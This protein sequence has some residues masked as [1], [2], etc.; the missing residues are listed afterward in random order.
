MALEEAVVYW[1]GE[2]SPLH[3]RI[4]G[5]QARKQQ[6]EMAQEIVRC[7]QSEQHSVIEAPTGVG[8][9]LGY[10]IPILLAGKKTLIA[11][12]TKVLQEQLLKKDLPVL[13]AAM[14][15]SVR[16]EML[17]GKENYLSK[18]RLYM[19]RE[20]ATRLSQRDFRDLQKIEKWAQITSTGDKADCVQVRPDASIW[21]IVCTRSQDVIEEEDFCAIAR[22]RA[23]AADILIVNQH[24]LCA[25]IQ[26][27]IQKVSNLLSDFQVFIIDE[28]HAFPET[29]GLM[30]SRQANFATLRDLCE[31]VERAISEKIADAALLSKAIKSLYDCAHKGR[32][33]F[34]PHSGRKS[35]HELC[36]ESAVITDWVVE[37]IHCI[38]QLNTQLEINA[39]RDESIADLYNRGQELLA[40]WRDLYERSEQGNKATDIVWTEVSQEGYF[41]LYITPMKVAPVVREA[42]DNTNGNWIFTSATLAIQ[43]DFSLFT[44][45]IGVE[46][47]TLCLDSPFNYG[48]QGLLYLPKLPEPNWQNDHQLEALLETALPVLQLTEGRAFLLFTSFKALDRAKE[49]LEQ[50]SDFKLFVQGERSSQ[51]L[52]D[53]FRYAKKSLLLGTATFWEGVDIKGAALSCVIIDK[54]PFASPNDPLV[55]A[56]RQWYD[57]AGRDFFTED[58]LARAI[59][60]LRQG[61]GRLIRSQ[62]DKGILLIGDVRLQSKYYGKT[63]LENLPAFKRCHDFDSVKKFWES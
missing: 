63:I 41:R 48:E 3:E 28:A 44:Q 30:F 51:D 38:E 35:W 25:D 47:R 17:K 46:A 9:T 4:E 7:V 5:F 31:D 39:E 54:L 55:K 34:A 15:C 21:S 33:Y 26:L 24:L 52:L 27:Q 56:R 45:R 61:I 36:A 43:Q 16:V 20:E 1:C 11:S 32:K 12:R 18:N 14:S 57:D 42:I 23:R 59:L 22:R 58:A 10:L 6:Q 19:A 62:Q 8:K 29:A 49:W 40:L 13:L 50:R 37:L 60:Q 2:K 53:N